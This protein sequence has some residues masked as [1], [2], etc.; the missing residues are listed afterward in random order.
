M[1]IMNIDNI[2]ILCV[3]IIYACH[4]C[5]LYI[6]VTIT[7]T[8][9]YMNGHHEYETKNLSQAS[10]VFFTCDSTLYTHKCAN[11][12]ASSSLLK[13]SLVAYKKLFYATHA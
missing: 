2:C 8:Y 10:N 13:R 5:T 6:H 3:H 4:E 9:I 1:H 11:D 7:I 12:I